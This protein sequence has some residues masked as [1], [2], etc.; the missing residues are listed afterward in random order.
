MKDEEV[1]RLTGAIRQVLPTGISLSK[2]KMET[3]LKEICHFGTNKCRLFIEDLIN[4]GW[5]KEMPG[6]TWTIDENNFGKHHEELGFS[7]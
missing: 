1:E 3:G 7:D 4:G 2:K 5:L 6:S